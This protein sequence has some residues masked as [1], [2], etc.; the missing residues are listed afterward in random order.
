MCSDLRKN[1]NVAVQA[2]QSVATRVKR[3]T[4]SFVLRFTRVATLFVA[5][6]LRLGQRPDLTACVGEQL[7]N[8]GSTALAQPN[9]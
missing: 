8:A 4:R 3:K 2:Y 6:I 5:R 7:L 1:A 9:Y